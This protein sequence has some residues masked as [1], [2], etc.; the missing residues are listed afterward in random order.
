MAYFYTYPGGLYSM[1]FDALLLCAAALLAYYILT[2]VL[3]PGRPPSISSSP[4]SQAS[5]SVHCLD[6]LPG[7]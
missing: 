7:K 5:T 6:H 3:L 2:Q 1:L 4:T